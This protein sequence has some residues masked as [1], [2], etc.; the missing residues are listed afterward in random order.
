MPRHDD[1]PWNGD[2]VKAVR[3]ALLISAIEMAR[4][5]GIRQ[6]TIEAISSG[7]M[8]ANDY[9]SVK[10]NRLERPVTR[11]P[12]VVMARSQSRKGPGGSVAAMLSR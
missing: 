9:V 7:R 2:R 3:G 12:K 11:H 8:T 1:I 5:L 10:L 4:R 6:R